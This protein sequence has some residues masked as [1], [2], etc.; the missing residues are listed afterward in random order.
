[1]ELPASPPLHRH[2]RLLRYALPDRFRAERARALAWLPPSLSRH[3]PFAVVNAAIPRR[4]TIERV[5]RS[6]PPYDL[7]WCYELPSAVAIGAVDAGPAVVVDIDAVPHL[8]AGAA[9][10]TDDRFARQDRAAWRRALRTI[11][12]QATT[13]VF[14]NDREAAHFDLANSV[15]VANGSRVPSFHGARPPHPVPTLT[16]V[17]WMAYSANADAARWLVETIVPELRTRLGRDFQVRLVGSAPR[18]LDDLRRDPNVFM[19]GYVADLEA[20]L[21]E[22]DVSVVPVRTGAGTRIKLFESFAAQVPVVST[23]FGAS[24]V[25]VEDGVHL[26]VA[27]EPSAFA[28]ACVKLLRDD[29]LRDRIVAAAYTYVA[30]HH[31]WSVIEQRIAATARAAIASKPRSAHAGQL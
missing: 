31:D 21:D 29:A 3:R 7:I 23:A 19:T 15:V 16:F 5:V 6:R 28:Q 2:T 8:E 25:G 11:G 12:E 30:E 22:A 20:E 9:H 14:S 13:V 27:D 10:M 26:L 18:E 17:G 4:R 1:M 24:G